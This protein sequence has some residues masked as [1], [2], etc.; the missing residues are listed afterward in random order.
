MLDEWNT[1]DGKRYTSD[2]VEVRKDASVSGVNL[3]CFRNKT[4]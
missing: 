3:K 1:V 4:F 2:Q